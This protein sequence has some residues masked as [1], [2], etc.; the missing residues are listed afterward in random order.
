MVVLQTM[1]APDSRRRAA[2]G[3]SAAAG[4]SATALVP[5]G[6]GSPWVAMLS[7]MVTGT[8]SSVPQGSPFN[9]RAS[10]ARAC[11]SAA[12]GRSK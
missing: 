3:A 8:P 11:A 5:S 10:D 12:S 1:T 6:T 9:Q 2:G 7:L 4:V